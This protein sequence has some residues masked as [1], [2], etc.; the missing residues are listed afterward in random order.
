MPALLLL[1]AFRCSDPPS[2]VRA[3]HGKSHQHDAEDNLQAGRRLAKELVP[4]RRG[5]GEAGDAEGGRASKQGEEQGGRARAKQGAAGEQGRAGK[6]GSTRLHAS[7][8]LEAMADEIELYMHIPVTLIAQP[9]STPDSTSFTDSLQVDSIASL[10]GKSSKPPP[11]P[12]KP[13]PPARCPPPSQCQSSS[14][15]A[16]T[17]ATTSA[18]QGA[19]DC[20]DGPEAEGEDAWFYFS[21]ENQQCGPV[22]SY[23]LS[24]LYDQDEVSDRTYI[25][26]PLVGG[27]WTPVEEST[28]VYWPPGQQ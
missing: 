19:G 12:S 15:A 27:A 21:S 1:L 20:V 23:Q 17:T 4:S 10:S 6:Q 8:V 9:L 28:L 3:P 14:L 24:R 5:E 7:S 13:P 26:S 22:S 11:P 25:W 2:C 16:A 18:A